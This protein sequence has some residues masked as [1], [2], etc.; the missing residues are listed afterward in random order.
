MPTT[1]GEKYS[2][3]KPSVN[4]T[5]RPPVPISAPTLTRLMLLTDATRT[6]AASTG[7]DSGSST[8]KKRRTGLYPT[9]VAAATTGAGTASRASSTGRTSSAVV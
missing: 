5:P 6:P 4:S 2:R 9:A 3:W 1:I 8:A 7:T